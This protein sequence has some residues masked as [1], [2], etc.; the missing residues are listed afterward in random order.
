M[1][2]KGRTAP[3]GEMSAA[4]NRTNAANA[5][6]RRKLFVERYLV[7]GNNATE[8]AEFVGFAKGTG[9]VRGSE[10]MKHPEVMAL[11]P[12]R[13]E[14]VFEQA[15]LSTERWAKE[16]AAI[17]HFDPR[18]LYDAE[19]AL[20]PLH[21]LPEHVARAIGTVDHSTEVDKE[22]NVTHHTKIRPNDKNVALANIGKH[23]G[24]FEKDNRQQLAPVQILV[25]LVG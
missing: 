11:L 1:A 25:N 21:K 5:S 6:R 16:M 3:T 9:S 17:G 10:L 13:V 24:V 20:I 14:E 2:R 15:V 4:G 22:G 19:G 12:N 8:A 7:N 23:L 18:E